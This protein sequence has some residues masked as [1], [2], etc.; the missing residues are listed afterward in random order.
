MAGDHLDPP[1]DGRDRPTWGDGRDR[2]T[3]GDGRDSWGDDRTGSH[4][5]G[6]MTVGRQ[7]A[8]GTAIMRAA[9]TE[10]QRNAGRQARPVGSP[11]FKI[12]GGRMAS[13]RIKHPI[14]PIIMT[15]T[16]ERTNRWPNVGRVT[17]SAGVGVESTSG[18]IGVG[19]RTAR[20]MAV[21]TALIPTR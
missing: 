3:W 12:K 20:C 16:G 7:H 11:F 10:D 5:I 15:K 17:M 19:L 9:A 2:P 13:S 1:G 4:S 8:V 21:R 6:T 18:G 14:M